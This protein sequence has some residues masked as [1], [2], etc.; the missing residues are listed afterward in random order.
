MASNV[1]WFKRAIR[2]L[3]AGNKDYWQLVKTKLNPLQI[4]RIEQEYLEAES[5]NVDVVQKTSKDVAKKPVVEKR[6]PVA[7]KKAP[8]KTSTETSVRQKPDSEPKAT[9]KRATTKKTKEK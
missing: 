2:A 1:K 3:S 8:V 4:E 7:E 6:K 5:N 9:K